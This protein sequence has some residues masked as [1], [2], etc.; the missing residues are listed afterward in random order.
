MAFTTSINKTT[1][2]N[3]IRV[4]S[5]TVPYVD[6]VSIGVWV[7]VGSRDE[8]GKT[9]GASHF[10]EHMLFKGT[11]TRS[12]RQIADEMDSIGG[13]LNAYTDKE[14]TWYYA[15]VLSEHLP[16]AAD[17]LS[18]MLLHSVLDPVELEREKN[19]VLEEIK[20]HEDAPD[21]L[22]H[23][24]FAQTLWNSH[25]LG[26]SVIGTK[27]AV[28][29]FTQ[30]IVQEHLS[31]H[32][33]PNNIVISAAGNLEHNALIELINNYFGGMTGTK[34]PRTEKSI[35][36]SGDTKFTSKPVEQVHICIGTPGYSQFDDRKYP[37]AVLD[38][39]LGGGMSSRL[40]QE[41]R[42]N[43]GLAYSVG[44]YVAS[45][46][47]GGMFTVYGGTSPD[48]LNEVVSLVQIELE[49]IKRHKVEDPELMRAK[50][51]IRGALVMGQESTSNRMSRMA[52][53]E[54]YFGRLI[55]VQEVIEKIMKVTAD[56]VIA[57]ANELFVDD[58]T[59][60]AAVGPFNRMNKVEE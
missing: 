42:E 47:E 58:Q 56:D 12:A 9:R 34:K 40:F 31:A 19:V 29:G 21:D 49:N 10:I 50:N 57:V 17:I 27:R 2:P 43:R 36:A 55:T 37:L 1:L 39:I 7:D 45:Y 20:R 51:Q 8:R 48:N 28:Q 26:Y 52:N 60:F 15:K 30:E 3:G 54:L 38:A 5:E 35:V 18:D 22:V 59:A 14:T 46:R 23:D 25:P 33:A 13:H 44:S 11:E 4:L 24:I 6:S 16:T 32:Y 41:I 53:S